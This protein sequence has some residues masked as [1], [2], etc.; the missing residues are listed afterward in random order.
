MR[1]PKLQ[2]P[3]LRK[4]RNLANRWRG[5]RTEELKLTEKRVKIG[6]TLM[7]GMKRVR[8][9]EIAFRDGS[10]VSLV[11]DRDKG[12]ISK[13]DLVKAFGEDSAEKFWNKHRTRLSQYLTLNEA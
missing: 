12:H 13:T 4:V 7:V 10:T 2:R 5:V 8:T 3:N 11:M 1:R 6:G 9:N